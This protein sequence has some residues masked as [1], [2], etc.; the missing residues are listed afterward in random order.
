[1][2]FYTSFRKA[3][4]KQV[5]SNT[6]GA[7]GLGGSEALT[8]MSQSARIGYCKVHAT[9]IA[10]QTRKKEQLD[11]P[12]SAQPWVRVCVCSCLCVQ[13]RAWRLGGQHGLHVRDAL[14]RNLPRQKK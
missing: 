8:V 6:S 10:E 9:K 3:I 4:F 12:K 13:V 2:Q 1:M 5:L 7:G 14:V 11:N